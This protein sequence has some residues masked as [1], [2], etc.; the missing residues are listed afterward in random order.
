MDGDGRVFALHRAPGAFDHGDLG[1]A[2]VYLLEPSIL[3]YLS[4]E[5]RPDF[6]RDLFPA[7]LA[8]GERL[9]GYVSETE[10][11]DVGTP[12]RYEEAQRRTA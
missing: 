10:L 7:A 3:S 1:N 2:A 6:V 12:E 5:G 4:D 8:G 11:P 9:Y